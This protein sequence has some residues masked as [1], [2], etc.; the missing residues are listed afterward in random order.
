MI[1]R[2]RA[3]QNSPPVKRQLVSQEPPPQP[4]LKKETLLDEMEHDFWSAGSQ[5]WPV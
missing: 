2:V 4:K 3:F 1:G 5:R